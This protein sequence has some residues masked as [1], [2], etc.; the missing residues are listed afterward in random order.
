MDSRWYGLPVA[1]LVLA[2]CGGSCP[3]EGFAVPGTYGVVLDSH[4]PANG[5]TCRGVDALVTGSTVVTHFTMNST[6]AVMCSSWIDQS[7]GFVAMSYPTSGS[8]LMPGYG[9]GS[10][11]ATTA[12]GCTGRWEV[13]LDGLNP[14]NPLGTT[15]DP[16]H[17]DYLFS[18]VFTPDNTTTCHTQF[19]APPNGC[20]DTWAVHLVP[21]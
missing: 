14:S 20:L 19:G 4:S 18:R 2:A 13:N 21:M 6:L 3:D 1:A 8:A 15:P 17:R 5:P 7:D 10:F 9:H 12:G 11:A 16:T